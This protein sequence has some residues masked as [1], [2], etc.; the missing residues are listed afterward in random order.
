MSSYL[1]RYQFNYYNINLR[2]TLYKFIDFLKINKDLLE[3]QNI[4]NLT[5][6]ITN[7]HFLKFNIFLNN[8][9][10]N[11]YENESDDCLTLD[12]L[13]IF[14]ENYLFA[15]EF[16]KLGENQLAEEKLQIAYSYLILNPSDFK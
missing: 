4:N 11:N 7:K 3:N 15:I 6:D 14:E 16:F 2:E 12:F 13:D 10:L 9:K 1:Y 5:L 8:L